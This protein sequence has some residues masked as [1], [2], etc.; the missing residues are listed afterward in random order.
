M[1]EVGSGQF[2]VIGSDGYS[3]RTLVVHDDLVNEV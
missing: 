2:N 3:N 1:E